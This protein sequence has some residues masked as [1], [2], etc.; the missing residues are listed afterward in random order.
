M[1]ITIKLGV[2]IDPA[3]II[4]GDVTIEEGASIWPCAVLRGDLNKIVIGEGSN[5]QEHVAIHGNADFPNIIGKNVSIGHGAVIHGATIGD[6]CIIG[7]HSTI[8]N[9]A[10]IGEDCIIAAGALITSGTNI[11]TR[12]LVLGVPGKVVK[13]ND[14]TIRARAAK[15]AEDYHKLRDEFLSGKHPRHKVQ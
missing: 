5:V 10:V 7:M 4:I 13:E 2:Y 11:P 9:G 15:N 1:S 8:L 12:S 14:S 3:S 6:H